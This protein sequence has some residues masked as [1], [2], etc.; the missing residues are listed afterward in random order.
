MASLQPLRSYVRQNLSDLRSA[1]CL[2]VTSAP[3]PADST[4]IAGTRNPSSISADE[5]ERRERR[6]R[7]EFQRRQTDPRAHAFVE[8]NV[9]S[10]ALEFNL[11][12][13]RCTVDSAFPTRE[14]VDD[15][16]TLARRA[17]LKG[18]GGGAGEG[19]VI[20]VGSGA[21]MDLAKAVADD[22][23][24][25]D[26]DQT[27]ED[28]GSLVL[29]PCTLGG[30][31]AACSDAPSLL[32]DTKEGMLLPHWLHSCSDAL[33]AAGGV[34]RR[35]G[36]VVTLDDPSRHLVV[37]P[38]YS[39]FRPARKSQHASA[40]SM[41]HVAAAALS[42]ALDAARSFDLAL[43]EETTR[44]GDAKLR[45]RVVEEMDAVASSCASVL[46]L[47][48][49]VAN[50]D[51][52][53]GSNHVNDDEDGIFDRTQAAREHLLNAIP[54]L[55]PLVKQ[56]SILAQIPMA[57]AGTLPQKLANAL[58]PAHFPQCHIV[59]YLAST[60]AGLCGVVSTHS[61]SSSPSDGKTFLVE[62]VANSIIQCHEDGSDDGNTNQSSKLSSYVSRL[63]T[64]A[65]IP[66]M[67][68]LAFGTPDLSA[69]V[70]SL[71][72]HEALIASLGQGAFANYLGSGQ[73]SRW[74]MEDVLQR[75]LNN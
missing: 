2:L 23:F 64:E 20:G 30:L 57:T 28:G 35:K 63:T 47:A 10:L 41:A 58:L 44:E 46:K 66:S 11:R 60:L 36:A 3:P 4:A 5:R 34:S 38:L 71:D 70:G 13:V 54:R 48:A 68:S 7:L 9:Q 19:V 15:A 32:L 16:A 62:K 73:D 55:A 18:G 51:R 27:A 17:G 67:A 39:A 50:S 12:A 37:P 1:P 25:D 49:G 42:I 74:I 52:D 29:A 72:S 75:S 69:L 40:P 59:T 26:G 65:G 61:R 43:E 6:E 22:L 56:S 24:G 53:G 14:G 31:W 8:R 45:R 21:A 33:P